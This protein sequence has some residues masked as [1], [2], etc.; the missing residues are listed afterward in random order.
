LR[1]ALRRLDERTDDMCGYDRLFDGL[2][3]IGGADARAELP[4]LRQLWASPHS[5]ERAAY[6]RARLALDP[7]DVQ[8]RGRGPV[9]GMLLGS[10]SQHVLR[11][12][13]ATVAVVHG[14][15]T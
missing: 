10:V 8:K 3:R 11:H 14:T 6:L 9:R 4:R 5:Y 1:S 7:D 12:S 13:T 15:A 2:A